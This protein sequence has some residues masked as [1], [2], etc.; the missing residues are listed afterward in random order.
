MKKRE[1]ELKIKISSL[2]SKALSDK[3]EFDK[4]K[5]DTIKK[6]KEEQ[7]RL[8]SEAKEGNERQINNWKN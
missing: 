8:L 3:M 2:E 4:E 1:K 6:C 5:Q 7:K